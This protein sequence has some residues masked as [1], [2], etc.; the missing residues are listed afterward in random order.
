MEQTQQYEK[1]NE[2]QPPKKGRPKKE[3]NKPKETEER[4]LQFTYPTSKNFYKDMPLCKLDL[5]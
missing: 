2:E 4:K 1:K 5:M 3:E